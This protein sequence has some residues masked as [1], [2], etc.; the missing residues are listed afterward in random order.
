MEPL[1]FV[2]LASFAVAC[3]VN[4][5]PSRPEV[6][7]FPAAVLAF[8]VPLL[9]LVWLRHPLLGSGLWA[10]AVGALLSALLLLAVRLVLRK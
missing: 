4:V 1:H 3:L 5:A 6:A 10:V 2:W 7:V 8:S 9:V